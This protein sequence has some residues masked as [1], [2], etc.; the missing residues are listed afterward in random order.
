MDPSQGVEVPAGPITPGKKLNIF[1]ITT[2]VAAVLMVAGFVFGFIQLGENN[3]L[4]DEISQLK[5]QVSVLQESNSGVV[6]KVLKGSPSAQNVELDE[7]GVASQDTGTVTVIN[8]AKYLEPEGWAVRFKY[9]DGVTDIAYATSSSYDGSIYITGIAVGN[10]IYDVNICGGKEKYN[11]YP[12]FLG[13]AYKWNTAGTH[14]EWETSPET[15]DGVKRIA[16]VGT[17]E[18][19]VDTAYGSGCEIGENADYQEATRLAKEL[20]DAFEKKQ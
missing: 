7:K 8:S 16:K 9:P 5:T 4:K 2:I 18:Y 17:N 3:K 6:K 12:F 1:L 19:F 14:E 11:Q 15:Y 10:K 20:F 13:S